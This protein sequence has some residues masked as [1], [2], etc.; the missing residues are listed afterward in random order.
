MSYLGE[1][2]IVIGGPEPLEFASF[3]GYYHQEE[4]VQR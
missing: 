3:V 2:Q 4:D 1:D